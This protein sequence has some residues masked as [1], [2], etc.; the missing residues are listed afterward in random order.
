MY[1]IT[2]IPENISVNSVDSKNS[3][4][5]LILVVFFNI[6]NYHGDVLSLR[7]LKL[8]D[9]NYENFHPDLQTN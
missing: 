9:V 6:T 7:N 8:A 4:L 3:I 5:I 2:T 1:M